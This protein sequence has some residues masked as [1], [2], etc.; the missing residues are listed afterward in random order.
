MFG[1]GQKKIK[2]AIKSCMDVEGFSCHHSFD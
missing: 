2:D 1:A